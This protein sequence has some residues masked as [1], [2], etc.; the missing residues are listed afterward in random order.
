M[1]STPNWR[2]PENADKQINLDMQHNWYMKIS[3]KIVE[4]EIGFLQREI[5]NEWNVFLE[6][7]PLAF[8]TI[9]ST[10]FQLFETTFTKVWRNVWYG[11]KLRYGIPNIVHHP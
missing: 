9:I 11:M 8:S 5:K 1:I 2:E 6:L 4:T 7:V 10:S 3:Q